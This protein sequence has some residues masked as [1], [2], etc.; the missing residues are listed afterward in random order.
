[1]IKYDRNKSLWTDGK[2]FAHA[3]E[4]RY[5]AVNRLAKKETKGRLSR[6]I[7]AAYFLDVHGV[8]DEVA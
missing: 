5:Y 4:I 2:Y 3:K 1:M 7:I 8:A 6:E